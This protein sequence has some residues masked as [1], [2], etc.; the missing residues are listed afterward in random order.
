MCGPVYISYE[1]YSY[2]IFW[3]RANDSILH[4]YMCIHIYVSLHLVQS[5]YIIM[6]WKKISPTGKFKFFVFTCTKTNLFDLHRKFQVA[7]TYDTN[8]E[9]VIWSLYYNLFLI[10]L[11]RDKQTQTHT[12]TKRGQEL[13]MWFSDSK[14][15]DRCKPI[16][17]SI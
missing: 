16:K 8:V 11:K 14:D 2:F 10:T 6:D 1:F 15:S 17:I 4:I 3:L 7:F 12:E 5:K 9:C 13:K